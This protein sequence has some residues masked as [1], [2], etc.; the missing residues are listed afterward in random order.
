M[1]INLYYLFMT[2]IIY[3]LFCYIN[4]QKNKKHVRNN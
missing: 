2:I 3:I 1:E 4:A